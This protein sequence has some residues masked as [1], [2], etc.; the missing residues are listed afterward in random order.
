MSLVVNS[1]FSGFIAYF[2]AFTAC[3]KVRLIALN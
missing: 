1:L 3:L 2:T